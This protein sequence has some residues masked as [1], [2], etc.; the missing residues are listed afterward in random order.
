MDKWKEKDPIPAL[1]KL[2]LAQDAIS[3]DV[4]KTMDEKVEEE[5]QKAV[6]YAESGTLESIKD[7]TKY[8]YCR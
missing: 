5:V 3:N 7:L 4:I 2:L 8:V 1:T 6:D